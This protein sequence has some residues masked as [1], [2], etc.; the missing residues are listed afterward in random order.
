MSNQ[1]AIAVVVVAYERDEMLASCIESLGAQSFS[2][3]QVLVVLNG[4]N[5][6]TRRVAT[7]AAEQDPRVTA[8]SVEATSASLARN[9]GAGLAS[10]PVLYFVDDDATVPPHV[11]GRLSQLFAQ[12]SELAVVGGPNVTP[13][14][15]PPF[16]HLNGAVLA[17][18]WGTGITH[19]RYV[20]RPEGPARERDLILCNLA[21]TA[22]AFHEGGAFPSLFGGEENVL[23]GH[24]Q[25]RG[26]AMWYCPDVWV[27]HHRRRTVSQ[28]LSQIYRYGWGRANAIDKSPHNAHPLYFLPAA[29]LVYLVGVPLLAQLDLRVL[30][31]SAVY[32]GGTLVASVVA[33]AKAGRLRWI[34]ALVLLFPLTHAAYAAGLVRQLLRLSLMRLAGRLRGERWA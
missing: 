1:P 6:A 32:F 24:L 17:S 5:D 10:A 14:H 15:D 19:A 21:V 3:F 27:H 25:Q 8:I 13:P 29:A 30:W 16:A 23:A 2:D 20:K 26:R 9:H 12:R 34:P 4:A 11:L 7:A 28:F 18:P 22:E 31:G 33:A